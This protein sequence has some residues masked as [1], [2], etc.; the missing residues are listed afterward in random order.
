MSQPTSYSWTVVK[1][2]GPP[3]LIRAQ[4]LDATTLDV[5]FSEAVQASDATNPANYQ[6]TGGAGLAV[7]S[8]SQVSQA[9]YILKTAPQVAGQV[10]S[11]T[12]SNIHD[13]SGN[14]I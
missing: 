6:I 11:L 3:V 7:L 12:A 2:I 1:E 13:L 5:I 10:Y 4:P 9:E 8:V 14:L